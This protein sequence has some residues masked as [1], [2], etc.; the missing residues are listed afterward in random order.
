[1]KQKNAK[2]K[3]KE[4]R[5]KLRK[6]ENVIPY[7]GTIDKLVYARP[8]EHLQEMI[9]HQHTTREPALVEALK[10]FSERN[11]KYM[12]KDLLI[13]HHNINELPFKLNSFSKMQQIEH[14]KNIQSLHI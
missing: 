8:F 6:S 4:L 9:T 10:I 12:F 14:Q 13:Y 2:V 5:I 11:I 3:F 7:Y 1:M